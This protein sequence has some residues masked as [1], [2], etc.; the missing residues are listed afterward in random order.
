MVNRS[1]VLK[2]IARVRHNLSRVKE[3]S[4]ISLET[5]ILICKAPLTTL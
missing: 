2:K 1:L 3:K 5:L 4:S